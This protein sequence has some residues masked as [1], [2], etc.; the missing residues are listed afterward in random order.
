MKGVAPFLGVPA[1]VRRTAIRPLGQP[2]SEELPELA[3]SLWALPEREY[4]YVAC[5]WL[6][7]ATRK[8]PASLLTVVEELVRS[9]SWWDT[10]DGL[11][12]SVANLVAN[13]REL[14]PDM[15]R[16]IEDPD[17][18]VAR[19]AILHQLGRAE[20]TD[21]DRLFRLCLVR[22]HEPEFLIR[23]AIGW[24]LRDYAWHE[25]DAVDALVATHRA[26]LSALTVREAT[27]NLAKARRKRRDV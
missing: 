19:V 25:P 23:K 15:D 3:R 20:R 1:P 4:A 22:A 17:F 6:E 10:V 12:G 18:W 14:A 16:W 8:G 24:A 21:A 27:K 26:Q 5:D 11:A 2:S 9:R 7:R 13:H